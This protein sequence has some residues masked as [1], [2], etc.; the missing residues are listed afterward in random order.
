L[1]VF[2]APLRLGQA[3]QLDHGLRFGRDF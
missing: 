3:K 2:G 1:F